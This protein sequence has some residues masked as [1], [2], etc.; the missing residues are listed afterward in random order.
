MT[1]VRADTGVAKASETRQA[2]KPH[3]NTLAGIQLGIR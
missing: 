2:A 1:L 3:V